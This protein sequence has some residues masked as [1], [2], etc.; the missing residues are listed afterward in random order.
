MRTTKFFRALLISFCAMVFAT[1]SAIAQDVITYYHT[2]T[3][4]SPIAATD[5]NG[6]VLWRED[7]SPYGEKLR[8][9]NS[10]RT[11]RMWFTGHHHDDDSGLT[12]A[13][14]RHYDPMVGRF[15][16]V[17]PAGVVPENQFSFNRYAYANNNPYAFVDPDGAEVGAAF[18][19]IYLADGG[20]RQT[21]D[22][23]ARTLPTQPIEY[24]ISGGLGLIA[25]PA[26]AVGGYELGMLALAEPVAA[27]TWTVTAAEVA[28][29]G[30]VVGNAMAPARATLEILEES[31]GAIHLL[32]HSS[33]GTVEIISDISVQGNALVLSGLHANGVG[34]QAGQLG[35][36]GINEIKQALAEMGKSRGA[37]KVLVQ[38]GVRSQG[39]MEG[40][41]PSL[42]EIPV[43]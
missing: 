1:G 28:A 25:L 20:N 11:N 30:A 9:E 15:M 27:T 7:Y 21:Y 43:E 6:N 4:G 32:A 36:Q 31:G 41:T 42:I 39:K 18:R 34:V 37:E 8:Q 10:P 24:A 40:R 22:P 3:A 29:G 14:A 23:S 13:G 35:R 38:G 19:A 33:R 16:G 2:D 17:D 26:F 5:A 12:Y